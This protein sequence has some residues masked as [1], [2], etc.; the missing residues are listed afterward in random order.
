MSLSTYS[1]GNALSG[2]VRGSMAF[3]PWFRSTKLSP[4]PFETAA[5]M[6]VRL[7]ARTLG[8]DHHLGKC[9]DMLERACC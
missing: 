9:H 8:Y 6:H 3:K 1:G 2:K 4:E 5:S 7:Y